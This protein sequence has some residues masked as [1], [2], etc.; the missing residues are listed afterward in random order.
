MNI[1]NKNYVRYFALILIIIS[2]FVVSTIATTKVNNII[3][4]ATAI[5]GFLIVL[6]QL[7]RDHKIKKAE[8]IYSLNTTFDS[9]SDI[10]VIYMKLKKGRKE[11]I[12]FSEEEGRLMGNYVTFFM[13]MNH[14]LEERLI[15][16]KMIDAIFSNK[17]FL[18]CN[19]ECTFNYQ[20]SEREI[21]KPIIQLYQKWYNYRRKNQLKELYDNYSL[22]NQHIFTKDSTGFIK[23][24]Q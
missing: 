4:I 5:F 15:S 12:T 20:L 17:F 18:F 19:N 7:S 3:T 13:I 9:D 24:N 8:F 14:L 21:N 10:S 2:I 1:I 6:Y 22:S 23:L 16:I 11:S